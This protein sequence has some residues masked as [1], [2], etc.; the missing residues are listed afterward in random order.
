MTEKLIQMIAFLDEHHRN[1]V[2]ELN[3]KTP[4]ELM[5]AVILSAQCTDKRVNIIT[6]ELFK[7][8]NRPEHFAGLSEEELG[9]LIYSCGF[10]R[11][12]GRN[13]IA[14]SRT[15][16]ERY[17]GEVPRETEELLKI[18]GLGN[19]SAA[20][21]R[22]VAFNEDALAVDTHVFRVSRRLGIAECKTADKVMLELMGKVD[23]N[24][25]SHFHHLLI[26]HGRYICKAQHPDCGVCKLTEL[27]KYYKTNGGSK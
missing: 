19:K 8:Y 18:P 23:K 20:V 1:A 26:H 10:Y 16:L 13:I 5:V 22:A 25:W 24:L 15:L 12:K 2:C 3:F 4:F 11:N 17:N 7:K 6:E 21:I 14:A 9:K 27:C